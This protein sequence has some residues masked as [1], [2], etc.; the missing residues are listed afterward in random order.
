MKPQQRAQEPTLAE[1]RRI[2]LHVPC[3]VGHAKVWKN[4]AR[5]NKCDS[6]N[7]ES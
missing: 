1:C 4:W 7:S 2:G 6:S 5:P 3:V